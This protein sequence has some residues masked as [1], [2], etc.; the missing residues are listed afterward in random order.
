MDMTSGN[1][2]V[3]LNANKAVLFQFNDAE[4][5]GTKEQTIFKTN[6]KPY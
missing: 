6:R 1:V 2:R 5:L 4:E 3:E